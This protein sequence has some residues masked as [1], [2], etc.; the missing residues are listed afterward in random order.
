MELWQLHQ[1]QSLPLDVKIAKSKLR[2][3]EWVEHFGG[4]VYVSFSG[5]KDST[6][7]LDLVRSEYPDIPA[8]FSDTGLEF[9][10]IR[11]FVKTVPDVTW[12]KPDMT[13]REVIEKHGYPVISKEQSDWIYRVRCGNPQVYRKNVLGIMPDGS[14]TRFHISEKWR[15]LLDAPFRI[16]AGCCVEMK[17]KP[18]DRYA[19]ETGR[20]PILGT[21][22]CESSLRLQKWLNHGCNAFDNKKPVSMPLSFWLE[23]DIWEYI[24]RFNIPY[25]RIYD[26]GYIRTGCI[27]CMFGVHLEP[28]P[29]RFQRLQKTHPKLWRYCMK[30]WSAGGLGL[31]QVLEYIGVPYENF[32]L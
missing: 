14:E 2:I 23:E 8:V 21:M 18:L 11:G 9:P 27:F 1:F 25:C 3:R 26:M 17:K 5:G 7:L 15:Y 16:G 20:V 22:A 4:D 12:L 10:E 32:L 24:H 13:F 19:K 28:E 29:N 6:V 30:E 31:R